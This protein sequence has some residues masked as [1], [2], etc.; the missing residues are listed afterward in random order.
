MKR[1]RFWIWF[2][3]VMCLVYWAGCHAKSSTANS[4]SMAPGNKTPFDDTR[5]Q[6]GPTLLPRADLLA[7]LMEKNPSGK[8]RMW[9]LPVILEPTS[10][11]VGAYRKAYIGVDAGLDPKD[12]IF[13]WLHD[14]ALGVSLAERVR[15]YCPEQNIC[16]LWVAGYWG[17]DMLTT[18][19]NEGEKQAAEPY[20]FSLRSVL[21]P[22]T[23]GGA[24]TSA[25]V[26]YRD[27]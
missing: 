21:G 27:E 5:W 2:V 14:S 20:P 16:R 13:L 6:D 19:G 9:R 24:N 26:R 22:Q 17:P 11:E 15:Q 25:T 12:R 18:L 1:I 4:I 10:G 7:A 3:T 8:R 23:N